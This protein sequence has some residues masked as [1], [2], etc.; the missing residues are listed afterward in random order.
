[1]AKKRNGFTEEELK[2]IERQVKEKIE[3]ERIIKARKARVDI[4]PE[5][6]KSALYQFKYGYLDFKFIMEL[7]RFLIKYEDLSK[8]DRDHIEFLFAEDYL[9]LGTQG[10][11]EGFDIS[12]AI[13]KI[14]DALKKYREA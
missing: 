8:E 10:V 4:I 11:P 1:M 7:Y 6:L 13:A 3:A 5:L 14:R 9:F 12:S 2:E